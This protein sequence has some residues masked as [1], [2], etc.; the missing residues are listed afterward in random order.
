M[1]SFQQIIAMLLERQNKST[2]FFELCRPLLAI[3]KTNNQ[4]FNLF[5]H[6]LLNTCQ[7]KYL[8]YNEHGHGCFHIF[9]QSR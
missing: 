2:R 6:I 8:K 7:R 3:N 5:C 1:N 9:S 4:H